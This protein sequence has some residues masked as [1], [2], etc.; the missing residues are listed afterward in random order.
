M[1]EERKFY[2]YMHVNNINNKKYIGIT[3]QERIQD[4]WRSDGS[5]YKTQVFGRAIN[6]HGWDNFK[7]VILEENL[8][9]KEALEK[10]KFYIQKYNTT[11]P[12][13]G[14][15]M[16]EG[17]DIGSWGI[18]NNHLSIPVYM[19][20]IDGTFVKKFPSMMEAERETGID[21]SAICACCKDKVLYISGTRWFY[22]YQGEK[23]AGINPKQH[24]YETNI[25]KQEKEVFQYDLDGNFICKYKSL[26]EAASNSGCDFRLIS[27]CCLGKRKMHKNFMWFYE[28]Q[29]ECTTPYKQRSLN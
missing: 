23:I 13:Y 2:V 26:S 21:N 4:R 18:L 25:S 28:Y 29:G 27:A 3:G 12:K 1:S 24:R 11:N 6:K 5:G 17:G 19:Y 16:S 10:E 22:E 14:Y 7:H 20:L 15:N 9:E 8:L